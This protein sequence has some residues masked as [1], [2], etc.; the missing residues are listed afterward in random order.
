MKTQV[1]PTAPPS[2]VFPIGASEQMLTG[3]RRWE[4]EG[5][6]A[7]VSPPLRLSPRNPRCEVVV[8]VHEV[9]SV[10]V[11]QVAVVPVEVSASVEPSLG[12][13]VRVGA[14]LEPPGGNNSRV[15]EGERE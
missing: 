14:H 3:R 13:C 7:P 10:D 4:G 6:A 12:A 2:P 11:G 8:Q 5:S 9:P 15:N 1:V